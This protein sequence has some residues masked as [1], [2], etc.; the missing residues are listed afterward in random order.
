MTWVLENFF[1]RKKIN[2]AEEDFEPLGAVEQAW[3]D[4][5]RKVDFNRVS[6]RH[7]CQTS[8]HLIFAAAGVGNCRSPKTLPLAAG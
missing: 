3:F 4:A 5:W 8:L 1:G 2:G 6:P 7:C